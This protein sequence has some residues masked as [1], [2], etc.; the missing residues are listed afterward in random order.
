MKYKVDGWNNFCRVFE[1][2]EEF[3]SEFC[4]NGG[5]PTNFLMV[6]WFNPIGGLPQPAVSKKEWKEKVGEI[7]VKEIEHDYICTELTYFLLDKLYI[8]PKRKYLVICDF[9]AC[10][11]F[12][13]D[14]N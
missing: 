12:E 5:I 13:Q 7:E 9:G 2:P 11:T 1:L 6:D 8:K 4:F 10:F 3:S 14:E